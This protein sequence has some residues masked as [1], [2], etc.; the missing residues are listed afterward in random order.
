MDRLG[1]CFRTSLGDVWG[2]LLDSFY[3]VFGRENLYN[4]HF[5]VK[6]HHFVSFLTLLLHAHI[7]IVVACWPLNYSVCWS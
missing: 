3:D 1:A 4:I 5:V 2:G 6:K 7:E